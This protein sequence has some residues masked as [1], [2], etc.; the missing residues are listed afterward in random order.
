MCDEPQEVVAVDGGVA[1]ALSATVTMR[2]QAA[3]ADV[4]YLAVAALRGQGFGADLPGDRG[5]VIERVV[6]AVRRDVQASVGGPRVGGAERVQLLDGTIGVDD[7]DRARQQPQT[8]DRAVLAE[9]ELDELAEHADPRFL[10]RR[11]IPPFEDADQPVRIPGA[12]RRTV[13]VRVRQ[14][15]VE[16][17]RAELQERL[18][19]GDRV[20]I[21]IDRAQ[22]AAVAVT[23]LRRPQQVQ[24]NRDGTEAV[25][26][27]GVAAVPPGSFGIAIEA[28]ADPDAGLLEHVQPGPV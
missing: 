18:I 23:E 20:V 5:G 1:E 16:R 13:P 17:R 25:A 27:T 15:Q 2:V 12:R 24:P 26:A 9:H 22:D 6:E 11:R 28:D 14:Q 4:H 21:D 19:G 8:L 10:P 3:T 7:N